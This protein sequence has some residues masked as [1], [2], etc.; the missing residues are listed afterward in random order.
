MLSSSLQFSLYRRNFQVFL[1]VLS[2]INASIEGKSPERD[3][4]CKHAVGV[5]QKQIHNN[6][7]QKIEE[8]EAEIPVEK[9]R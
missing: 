5:L 9:I 6:S 7:W 4:Q 2:V 1:A 3:E 8:V